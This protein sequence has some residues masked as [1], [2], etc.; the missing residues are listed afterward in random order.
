[1]RSGYSLTLTPTPTAPP[2]PFCVRRRS[3]FE[4]FIYTTI[5]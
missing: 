4:T 1:M 3:V 2:F 5:I